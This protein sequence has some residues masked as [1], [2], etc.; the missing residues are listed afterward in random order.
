MASVHAGTLPYTGNVYATVTDSSGNPV[1]ATTTIPVTS[2]SVTG[3]VYVPLTSTAP[4]NGT[5]N[6]YN[7]STISASNL[8]SVGTVDFTNP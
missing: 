8:I 3:A 7:S 1:A 2:G 5:V 4:A 6:I